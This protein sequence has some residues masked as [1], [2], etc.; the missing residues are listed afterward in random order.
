MFNATSMTSKKR[1]RAEEQAKEQAKARS[2]EIDFRLKEEAKSFKQQCD[3]LMISSCPHLV[4]YETMHTS[5]VHA[6]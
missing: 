6:Y 4:I 3:V 5:R 2:D 1:R